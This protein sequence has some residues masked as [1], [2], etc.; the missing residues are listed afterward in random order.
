MNFRPQKKHCLTA[1]FAA[2][3]PYKFNQDGVALKKERLLH[4]I[5]SKLL[6][7]Q[8]P[9][10][11]NPSSGDIKTNVLERIQRQRQIICSLQ[12]QVFVF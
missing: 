8:L 3:F 6:S 12:V 11:L 7:L 9:L 5:L 2:S 1:L 4:S 10:L